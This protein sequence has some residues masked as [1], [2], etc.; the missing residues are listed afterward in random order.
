M[1][2]DIVEVTSDD[3]QQ[4]T[5]RKRKSPTPNHPDFDQDFKTNE[6]VVPRYIRPDL[7][8]AKVIIT[9]Y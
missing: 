3:S 9:L 5:S 7:P 8:H 6:Y 1:D 2:Y 4:S